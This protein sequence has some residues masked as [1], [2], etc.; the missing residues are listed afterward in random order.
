MHVN[1]A[2]DSIICKIFMFISGFEFIIF[3]EI[4]PLVVISYISIDWTIELYVQ[5]PI[6][7]RRGDKD[8]LAACPTIQSCFDMVK[9]RLSRYDNGKKT[10]SRTDAH[11]LCHREM[12][13][14]GFGSIMYSSN[15]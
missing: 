15:N 14:R 6:N 1:H 10:V 8:S 3:P 11:M 2:L 5:V 9:K 12:G 4:Y 7:H 13:P